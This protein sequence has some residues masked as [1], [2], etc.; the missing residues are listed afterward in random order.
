ETCNGNGDQALGSHPNQLLTHETFR[1]WQHLYN[2]G[3]VPGA[4]TGFA[5][6]GDG[7]YR[8]T[9]GGINAPKSV[10]SGSAWGTMWMKDYSSDTYAANW[11]YNRTY[12]NML[13]FGAE[14]PN[15]PPFSPILT[16]QEARSLDQK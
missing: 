5:E 9:R 15:L 14:T 11:Q 4:Y 1:L 3:L 13:V 12:G 7:N 6:S 10:F 16:P 8:G 2:A